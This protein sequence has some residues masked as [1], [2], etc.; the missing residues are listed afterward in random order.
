MPSSVCVNGK[1]FDFHY[2]ATTNFIYS[3]FIGDIFISQIFNM[4]KRGWS[5]VLHSEI[6]AGALRS[7]SG[8]RTRADAAEYALRLHPVTRD[9]FS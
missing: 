4:G 2:K 8:F 5:V 3:F 1:V 6:P 7:V 9:I